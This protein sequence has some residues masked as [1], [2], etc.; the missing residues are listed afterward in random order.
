MITLK[1]DV[2]RKK[3]KEKKEVYE[4]LAFRWVW[5]YA[6]SDNRIFILIYIFHKRKSRI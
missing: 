5:T 1:L 6:F 4:I 3:K 2:V